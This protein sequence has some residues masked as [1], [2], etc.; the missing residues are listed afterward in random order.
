MHTRKSLISRRQWLKH[1]SSAAAA[2]TLFPVVAYAVPPHRKFL[3]AAARIDITPQSLPIPVSGNIT[4]QLADKVSDPLH[5]RALLL[6]NGEAKLAFAVVDS[7]FMDQ[8]MIDR[9]K[10]IASERT[11]ISPAQMMVS[12]THAHSAPPVVG[13]H[14]SIALPEYREFLT[15][16]IADSIIEAAKRWQPAQIGW[17]SGQC[18]EFIHCRR[19]VMKPGT[20]FTIPFTDKPSNLAQMNPGNENP[21]RICQTG[22][23]DSALPLLAVKTT[24]GKPLGALS[25]RHGHY[26]GA[27]G[28]SADKYGVF[29]TELGRRL[30]A[31]NSFVGILACGTLGDSNCIDF[32]TPKRQFDYKQVG[33]RLAR[34]AEEAWRSVDWQTWAPISANNS[35]MKLN[36]RMP[37][38]GETR[39]AEEFLKD[40]VGD[41]PIRNWEENY[42][43][44]TALLSRLPAHRIL[45]HQVIRIGEM[46]ITTSPC[47]VFGSTGLK[48]QR[49][50]P[51]SM[52]MN[53]GLANG[54]AG[55]LPPPDEH[56]LGGY[57]TWRAR[58]S[59]LEE[60]AEIQTT[61]EIMRLLGILKDHA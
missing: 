56:A 33:E 36:V 28:I 61:E 12:A 3:A 43:R 17:A 39:A 19:W 9:A 46:A 53:I 35:E 54:Y 2:T 6:D 48:W 16:R 58:S 18:T 11:G 59:C 45:P 7:L 22:P 20:A 47:E 5:V 32:S 24:D 29:A 13:V 8:A 23:I 4:A 57:S 31:G 49:N 40:T 25:V 1:A 37:S 21:N 50:S 42:A 38:A 55:Y 30:D 15:E 34:A 10:K 44:E 14:G 26:A 41:R 27:P 51:F 52:Q 60:S